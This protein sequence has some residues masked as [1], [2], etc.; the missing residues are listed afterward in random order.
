[1]RRGPRSPASPSRSSTSPLRSSGMPRLRTAVTPRCRCCRRAI[2]CDATRA[3]FRRTSVE[4]F[5]LEAGVTRT[6]TL[7]LQPGGP[8]E[9][10]RVTADAVSSRTSAGAVAEV[11]DGRLLTMTPWRAATSAS[12]RG[13]RPARRRRPPDRGCPAREG[14]RRTSRVLARP[15]TTS[16]STV[17]TTTTCS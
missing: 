2:T 5:H 14:H 9:F 4:P 10:V 6:L 8:H 7:T 1:M 11:F 17:S 12:T 15:R 13:R 16:C 3:G